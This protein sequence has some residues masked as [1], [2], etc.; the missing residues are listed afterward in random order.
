VGNAVALE[1]IRHTFGAGHFSIVAKHD[2]GNS[3][4]CEGVSS[5]A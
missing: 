1:H 5:L 3:L 4:K 2:V